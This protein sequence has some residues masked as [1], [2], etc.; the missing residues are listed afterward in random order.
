MFILS[1]RLDN[2]HKLH[3]IIVVIANNSHL[4]YAYLRK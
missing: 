1:I 3:Y 4:D 2:L